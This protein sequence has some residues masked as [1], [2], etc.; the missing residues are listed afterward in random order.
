MDKEGLKEGVIK[1]NAKRVLELTEAALAEGDEPLA[2]INESLIPAMSVVGEKMRRGDMFIPE[3]LMS[4]KAM[5]GS[6]NRLR[7]LIVGSVENRVGKIVVGTVKGDLHDIGKNLVAML[8]EA[9]AFEVVNLGVDVS[10]EKFADAVVEHEPDILG[11][12]ALLTTT[13]PRMKDT[14][15]YLKKRGL[16]DKVKVIVGGAPVT[17]EFAEEVGADGYAPDAA[18]AVELIKRL[19]AEIRAARG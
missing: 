14:V 15:E 19:L 16:R 6:V 3:V 18:S 17:A 12:S 9:N 1:G 7:P 8:S 2:I 4:A 11:M 5:T 10:P 13:M